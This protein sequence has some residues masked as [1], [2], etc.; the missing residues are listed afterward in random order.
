MVVAWVLFPLVMLAVCLGCGLAVERVAGWMLPGGLLLSVGLALVIVASTLTTGSASTASLTTP[1]VVLLALAGYVSS[2]RRLRALRPDGWA[3]AVGLGVFAVCAAPLVVSGNASFLGYFVL[4]DIG[5]HFGLIDRVLAHG[6]TWSGLPPS[7]YQSLLQIYLSSSYP[8]GAD[9]GLGALRPLVAQDVAWI[10]QPYLAMILTF[11]GLALYE[12]LRGVVRSR[13]L[14]ALCAF[15]AAQTGLLYGFYLEASIK[16]IAT[17]WLITLTVA[18]VVATLRPRFRPRIT[19]PLLIVAVAGLDVLNL[20]IVPWLGPPLGLFV[21]L[22]AW[23]RRHAMRRMTGA[24]LATAGAGAAV[25]VAALVAPLIGGASTF[26]RTATQVLTNPHDIGNLVGPLQK[27]QLLGIWPSGDFRLPL[28]AHYRTGYALIGLAIGSA[29]LGTLWMLRRRSLAPLLLLA[30]SGIAAVYLL[31]RASPYAS[32][33]TLM[34]LSVAVTLTAMLGAAALHHAGR[35]VEGWVL[36]GVLAGGILWTNALAYHAASI[37]PRARFAELAAIGERFAGQQP[38]FYNLWDTD[39]VHF[40]RNE[41][42]SVPNT[43]SAPPPLGPGVPARAGDQTRLAWDTNDIALPYLE[44]YRLLVLGRSPIASRPPANFRLAYQGRFYSVWQ[45]TS[46]PNVLEHISV[47]GG[48]ER[49]SVPS[50]RLVMA[51]AARAS[52]E[53]AQLAYVARTPL[54]TLVPTQ[55]ARP[56]DWQPNG[57]AQAVDGYT[58]Q[59]TP[60]DGSIQGPVQ[61]GQPG[62]FHVWLEGSVSQHLLIRVGGRLVGSVSYALASPGQFV[63]VGEVTLGAGAQQVVIESRTRSLTPG[64]VLPGNDGTSETL[65]PL[66]LVPDGTASHVSELAPAQAR[67]LCRRSLNWIEIVR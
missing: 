1:V 22:A 51:A 24:R 19:I 67:S 66:V 53:Q 63:S 15:A 32:A 37:A 38:A 65:G 45:R 47:R 34:I 49:T 27:W 59:I 28:D 25:L 52:R 10:F 36:A 55:A 43:W 7:A 23:R 9:V 16:E 6:Q 18:L 20:A 33:K 41:A 4:S 50:C 48:L 31:S 60:H 21:A 30:A 40:L 54:P 17:T 13:P 61:I 62:R 57:V 46:A 5:V 35:R 2:W 14:R 42:P 64:Y 29:L 11:G 44:G 26:F 3:I 8:I 56:P 39:A 58:V 12:L